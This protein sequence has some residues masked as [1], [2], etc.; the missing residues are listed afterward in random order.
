MNTDSGIRGIYVRCF[1]E[2]SELRSFVRYNLRYVKLR[3]RPE[4][5]QVP[6]KV[7]HVPGL[8]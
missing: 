4:F 7:L 8:F 6:Y 5:I 3:R 1:Y 2:L